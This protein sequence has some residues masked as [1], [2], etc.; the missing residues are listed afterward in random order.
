MLAR[1]FRLPALALLALTLPLAAPAQAQA[2]LKIKTT[3]GTLEGTATP[4]GAVHAFKGIPYAAPPVG[5]LRWAPPQPAAKFQ[6]LF[7]AKDYGNHCAQANSFADMIFHDAGPSEDCLSLN[8]WTPANAKPGAKLPVMFW[9]HG[10]GYYAGGASEARHDGAALAR[11]NVIIVTINYRLGI[12]GFFVH[13]ELTA[14]S[15]HHASGNYGLLDQVAALQWTRDNIAAFGGDPKNITIFG[16]SAGSFA[17]SSLMASPLSKNMFAK[18]IGESGGALASAVLGQQTL[19]DRETKDAA[20]AQEAFSTSKLADL[21][22]LPTDVILSGVA[23][24]K[25][26][27]SPVMDGYFFPKPV[28]DIYAAG[29][30]SHVP[31]I[32]GWNNDEMRAAIIMNP[33]K[34]T[35]ESFAADA[36]KDYGDEAPAFLKLYPDTT[37]AEAVTSAGDLISDRFIDY[38]TWR[39]L[40][41]QTKTGAAPVYRYL[42]A[43]PAPTDKY[44]PVAVGT[45]HS[46][47]IEYVFG[48]LDSRP[49][50]T[51]TPADR[52]MSDEIQQYWT[53]FAKTGDPNGKSLPN[54]PTYQPLDYKVLR[55]DAT[56]SAA[57]DAVRERYLFLDKH[58]LKPPTP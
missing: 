50:A 4:D 16:E 36:R 23:S 35:A 42:F 22:K 21:R 11:R 20:F 29:E 28:A 14:A 58:P 3:L 37:D 10:G 6:G 9:I 52:T 49:E 19:A 12:F 56:I 25:A 40:E 51:F 18:A 24:T 27:F 38:S 7:A 34:P 57:P 26:H 33:K 43:L 1:R 47:D 5:N 8:I 54:W 53:N 31:L 46:D 45:F 2:P 13:P 32:A 39:W 41:A 17:V 55:L 44:H 30:Q 48:T 15:P